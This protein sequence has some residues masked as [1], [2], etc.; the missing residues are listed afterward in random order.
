MILLFLII[1][2]IFFGLMTLITKCVCPIAKQKV[3]I[4]HHAAKIPSWLW[5]MK[6]LLLLRQIATFIR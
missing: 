4:I 1:L 6:W 5:A 3:S 2:I